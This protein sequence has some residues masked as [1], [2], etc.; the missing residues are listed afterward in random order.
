ME[1]LIICPLA[2]LAGFIDA[3]AGGG[4]FISLPAYLIAGLP[5]HAAIATNKFSACIG[6]LAATLRFAQKGFINLRIVA[7]PLVT[8][9]IGSW[10]GAKIALGIP[11]GALKTA[12]IFIIPA[13]AFIV[14]KSKDFQSSKP[15]F[16]T[17]ATIAIT[18]L[19][20]LAIGLYDGIYGPGTGTFLFLMFIYIARFGMNDAAGATKI[21]NLT[22]NAAALVIFIINGTVI[23]PLGIIAA[24]FAVAGNF[25]GANYFINKGKTIVKPAI[26][27]VLTIFLIKICYEYFR[28]GGF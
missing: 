14:I 5:P 12:M 6:T 15:K 1:Y 13:T 19:L 26:L 7:F 20:T 8:A 4:G 10:A 11:E 18:T 3:I 2:F 21:V 28:D 9:L 17:A 22:T 25:I 23:F 16:P 24:V 27:T